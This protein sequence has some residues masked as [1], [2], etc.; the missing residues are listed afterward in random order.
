MN[1]HEKV[2]SHL[3]AKADAG[4]VELS[5]FVYDLLNREIEIIEALK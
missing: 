3:A 2:E 4:G 1:L 5:D